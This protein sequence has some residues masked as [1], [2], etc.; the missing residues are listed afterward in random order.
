MTGASRM[1]HGCGGTAP[2]DDPYPFRCRDA[3]D[4]DDIDHLLARRLDAAALGHHTAA[5]RAIYLDAEANPF[6]RYRE[7]FHSY[8]M[9]RA[10]GLSDGDFVSIVQHLDDAIAA[11]DG[12]GFRITP[13]AFNPALAAAAGLQPPA[14][15]WIKR[16]G[17]RV[18]LAQARHTMGL[19]IWL[20]VM[21]ALGRIPEE[22]RSAARHR[23]L[24]Q[25]GAQRRRGGHSGRTLRVFIPA[26][27]DQPSSSG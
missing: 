11:A 9:A 2:D 1:C 12:R 14:E 26:D 17:Q 7:L 8:R 25:R 6:L 4:D 13:Y 18:R 3:R 15:L 21:E 23:E 22:E 20:K 16:N 10:G 5:W 27:A 24:R 19:M